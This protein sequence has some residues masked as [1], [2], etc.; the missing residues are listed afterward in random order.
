M[1]H[2]I[3]LAGWPL[4]LLVPYRLVYFLLYAIGWQRLL[5][6]YNADGRASFAYLYWVTTVREAID[7]LLPV[8]SVGGGVAGVRLLRW[9]GIGGTPAASSVIVEILLTLMVLFAFAGVGLVLLL[10]RGQATE[11]FRRVLFAFLIGLPAPVVCTLLLRYGSVFKRLHRMIGPLVGLEGLEEGAAALD[12][13]VTAMLSRVGTLLFT[14]ALQLIAMFSASF[15]VWFVLRLC[16]HPVSVGS[17][18]ILESM[19]ILMR[20]IAFFVPAGIGVQEVGLVI[21]GQVLGISGELALAVSMAKRVREV[22]CGLPALA[23]WQWM[24]ARRLSRAPTA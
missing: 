15:E 9:R 10:N 20:H 3:A 1:L 23:S 24:E 21:F 2:A 19:T 5:H 16:Q 11:Q 13:D 14:G 8:A 6:P 7:R 18:V 17:A 4:L 22:L 12:R